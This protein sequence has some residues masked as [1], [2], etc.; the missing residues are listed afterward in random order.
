MAERM[1]VGLIVT[2]LEDRVRGVTPSWKE[3]EARSLAAEAAGFDSIWISDHLIHKMPGLEPYGIWECWSIVSALA[4]VTKRVEIGTWVLCTGWRNPA[5]LAK[6]ADTVDEISG[7]RLILGLGAG[8]HEPEYTAFGFPFDNRVSRFIESIT[9]IHGLLREGHVDFEGRF[10]SARD[11][12]LRPRGPRPRGP[13]LMIGTIA[14]SPLAKRFGVPGNGERMLE[15][16]AKYADIWNVPWINDPA[17]VP[18]VH[19]LLD[20]ACARAGRDPQSVLRTHGIMFDLPGW[21]NEPGDR[22]IRDGRVT[23]GAYGGDDDALVE[24]LRAFEAAG[25]GE[26]H[27]QLDPETPARIESFG[28]VLERFRA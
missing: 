11:C 24:R 26:V 4:A 25:V 20:A 22:V 15:I 12:E 19:A 21:Q 23:M 14:G 5:L 27:I 1:H 16:V 13:K 28:R 2:P 7:G 18:A 9:I 6:M 8:W 3:I 17:E 10:Y